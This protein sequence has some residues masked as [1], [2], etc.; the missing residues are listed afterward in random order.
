MTFGVTEGVVGFAGP[1]GVGKSTLLATFATLRRPNSGVLHIL[2]HDIANTADL[3]AARARIG[4]LP[5]RF[6][7]AESMT[8]GEFVAYAAYYKRT[9]TAVARSIMKRLDLAE[10]AGTALSLLP[11]DVRLRAG[12]AAACVHGPD[13]LVLDDPF[14][15]LRA[16]AD[17]WPTGAAGPGGSAYSAA[18]AELVPVLRSLAPTVL[19]SADDTETLT[20]W[21]DRLLTLARGRLSEQPTHSAAARRGRSA[22]DR[23]V[24]A[25]RRVSEDRRVPGHR[26][27]AARRPADEPA[28]PPATP[29]ATP[30]AGAG[31]DTRAGRPADQSGTGGRL[32]GT[33]PR[34]GAGRPRAD[35]RA[36][37][38]TRG[39][40]TG[41]GAPRTEDASAH[42]PKRKRARGAAG[43]P[44][45]SGP[46]RRP[47]RLALPQ[48]RL[49]PAVLRPAV[50]GPAA[51]LR[52]VSL[53]VSR[54]RARR[55]AA[56]SGAGV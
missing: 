53:P 27:D 17:P 48:V 37:A 2:G 43:R 30:P 11:P 51:A 26:P 9:S 5:A 22:A 14:G 3:R 24:P 42:T 18:M 6:D 49:R 12:L 33:D 52:Q 54:L 41:E 13:L 39:G 47:A 45:R 56:G 8:A 38:A 46:K 20:G 1:P 31:L 19:V 15:D 50:L 55:A 32:M 44:R 21:C 28:A 4:Y 23:R 25:D 35:H 29:P 16:A 34:A 10:A 7:R 40:A 36:A